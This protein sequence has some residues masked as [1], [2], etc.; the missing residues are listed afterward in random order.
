MLIELLLGEAEG[1]RLGGAG[2]AAR[3]RI[4]QP[5]VTAA[6]LGT[7]WKVERHT[8][9]GLEHINKHVKKCV[10]KTCKKK[11]MTKDQMTIK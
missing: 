1:K 7:V 10:K 6:L 11:Y 3:L 2:R 8:A 9:L 4:S 5:A